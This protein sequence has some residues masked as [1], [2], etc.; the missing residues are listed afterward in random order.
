MTTIAVA[1]GV[2]AADSQVTEGALTLR[3]EKIVRLPCGGLA[4]GCGLYGE[5][6]RGLAWLAAGGKGKPPKLKE[7][8][9]LV[10]YGD[11]RVGCYA[12]TWTFMP[13]RGGAA[14]GSGAQAALAAMNHY[15]ASA[16]QAVLAAASVDPNTSAPVDVFRVE[17]VRRRKKK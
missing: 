11:G 9:I 7:S 6:R 12:A 14:I 5:V 3:G 15:G 10:A 2:M 17:P 13:L 1:D 16:E 8:E 4:G